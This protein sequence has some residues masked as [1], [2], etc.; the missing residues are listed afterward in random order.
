[1]ATTFS[2]VPKKISL[3]MQIEY[4]QRDFIFENH[5][6]HIQGSIPSYLLFLDFFVQVIVF[7][8]DDH[9]YFKNTSC[10]N[11]PCHLPWHIEKLMTLYVQNEPMPKDCEGPILCTWNHILNKVIPRS[12]AKFYLHLSHEQRF[13]SKI[14]LY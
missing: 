9:A 12:M 7:C 5:L 10:Q 3:L 4:W 8:K 11:K 6:Q 13:I 1:M 2:K 14:K